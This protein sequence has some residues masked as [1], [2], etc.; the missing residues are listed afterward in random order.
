MFTIDTLINAYARNLFFVKTHTAGMSHAD[1]LAQPPLKGNCV[2]WIVGHIALYRNTVLK[3]LGQPAVFPD[4]IALRY[5]AGSEPVL[6]NEPGLAQFPALLAALDASQEALATG[7]C[8]LTTER[9][10]EMITF[11]TVPPMPLSESVIFRLRHEAYHTGQ[12][13]L[14]AELQRS[15]S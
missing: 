13:E 1:S 2:N 3:D 12:L 11:G 10:A 5:R 6:H 9:G 8:A 14:L 15:K 4:E 7:L